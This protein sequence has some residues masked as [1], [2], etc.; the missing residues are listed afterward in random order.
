MPV[1]HLDLE[2]YSEV[3]LKKVGVDVY[4]RHPS[5][6]VLMTAWAV[7]DGPIYVV[8]GTTFRHFP[9]ERFQVY[10]NGILDDSKIY[11]WTSEVQGVTETHKSNFEARPEDGQ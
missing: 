7:D 5:T 4:A 8:T 6:E 10:A 9:R 3:D 11:R 1:L 2:T